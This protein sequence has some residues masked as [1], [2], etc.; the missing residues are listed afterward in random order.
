MHYVLECLVRPD[1]R[2]LSEKIQAARD[3][4]AVPSVLRLAE[5]HARKLGV[6]DDENMQ[7]INSFILVALDNDFYCEGS[8]KVAIELPFNVEKE[9]YILNG[10]L[11]KVAFYDDF[12]RITDYKT[13]KSK[14]DFNED[15][16][17]GMLYEMIVEELF[18]MPVVV[19]FQFLKFPKDPDKIMPATGA[20]K[21]KHF[22]E[23]IDSM[24]DY[25][26]NFDEE[27][28]KSN[29]AKNGKFVAMHCGK[30]MPWETKDDGSPVHC[31]E[32]KLP[33]KYF[34]LTKGGKVLKSSYVKDELKPGKGEKVEE[35]FYEG[36]PAWA[37]LWREEDHDS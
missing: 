24:A 37:E 18:K 3:I 27:T 8:E 12:I 16:T 32:Y 22:L 11:D 31:C 9:K 6:S 21:R 5:I 28:A 19:N 17:Q 25:I 34:C 30:K 10:F 26:A 4:A 33:K 36:C 35:K 7:M 29:Y 2:K 20:A 14:I 13:S 23:W 15:A 1:R